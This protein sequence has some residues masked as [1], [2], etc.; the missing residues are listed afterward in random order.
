MRLSLIYTHLIVFFT[1]NKIKLRRLEA[2]WHIPV[3][4]LMNGRTRNK[5]QVAKCYTQRRTQSILCCWWSVGNVIELFCS[6]EKINFD[7]T[8]KHCQS[9]EKRSC[10]KHTWLFVNAFFSFLLRE[11]YYV[12]DRLWVLILKDGHTSCLY[13]SIVLVRIG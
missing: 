4:Q 9:S 7:L 1:N 3:T 12:K 5:I 6:F 8:K 13:W 10:S 2:K 11:H